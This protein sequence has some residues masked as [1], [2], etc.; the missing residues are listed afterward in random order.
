M[1]CVHCSA[2]VFSTAANYCYSCG[3]EL[4]EQKNED[5]QSDK[6][7]GDKQNG[8]PSSKLSY[9][10]FRKR[11]ADDRCSKFKRK[12]C[13]KASKQSKIEKEETIQIG[14]MFWNE[15]YSLLSAKRGSNMPLKIESNVDN[16][17]LKAKSVEKQHRFNSGVVKSSNA[18]GYKLLYPDKTEVKSSFSWQKKEFTLRGY[19]EE[20]GKP[21]S[22]IN[23]YVCSNM[24][25]LSY[26]SN[27]GVISDS[28]ESQGS[29]TPSQSTLKKPATKTTKTTST[30]T[31]QEEV[32]IHLLCIT[33]YVISFRCI[34]IPML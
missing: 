21:Y 3:K 34:C 19:K 14:V 2:E 7:Q 5:K 28:D 4:K 29:D 16:E 13:S 25:Y 15:D 8:K 33:L 20:L 10:D 27:G 26:I 9:E 31:K 17:V 1:F 30:T 12:S 6:P 32:N 11:K 18:I 22:R 24:D 23:F